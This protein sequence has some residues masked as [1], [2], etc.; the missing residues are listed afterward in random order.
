[1]HFQKKRTKEKDSPAECFTPLSENNENLSKVVPSASWL[2]A[3]A[4]GAFEDFLSFSDSQPPHAAVRAC[5]RTLISGNKIE[6]KL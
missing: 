4:V 6:F 2:T 1:L 5:R 3:D